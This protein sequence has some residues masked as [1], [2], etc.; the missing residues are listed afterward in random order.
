MVKAARNTE[1]HLQRDLFL[2]R[3]IEPGFG[4]NPLTLGGD[5]RYYIDRR[6]MRR[7]QA[8][9]E[10]RPAPKP[11]RAVLNSTPAMARR[12]AEHQ[13]KPWWLR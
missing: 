13:F 7:A 10:A 3:D 8:A 1:A 2:V 5:G 11:H 9:P 12:L 4:W 6:D